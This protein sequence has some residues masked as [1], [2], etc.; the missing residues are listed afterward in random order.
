MN[1]EHFLPLWTLHSQSHKLE[2]YKI[3]YENG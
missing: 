2:S 3:G 1:G